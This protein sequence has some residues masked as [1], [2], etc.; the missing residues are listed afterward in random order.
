MKKSTRVCLVGSQADA[1]HLRRIDAASL[2]PTK[3]ESIQD[4]VVG[5]ACSLWTL[6]MVDGLS[7]QFHERIVALIFVVQIVR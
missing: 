7:T 4:G 1:E 2:L 5:E 6:E 3:T